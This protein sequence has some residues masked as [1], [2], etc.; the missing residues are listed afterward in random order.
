[1]FCPGIMDMVPVGS[2]PE[3]VAL[4][5]VIPGGMDISDDLGIGMLMPGGI[6]LSPGGMLIDGGILLCP[7]GIT[8][9]FGGAM[10]IPVGIG[11]PGGI[12][13][14]GGIGAAW[15]GTGADGLAG[16]GLPSNAPTMNLVD[17]IM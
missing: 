8:L 12:S 9:F 5:I 13:D 17:S 15:P 7:G 1:M 14:M 16:S 3:P 6:M 10:L 2:I 11:I 4:G